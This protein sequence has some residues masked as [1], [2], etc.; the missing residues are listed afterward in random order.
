MGPHWH[1]IVWKKHWGI[2]QNVFFYVA[3]KKE[4]HTSFPYN[5]SYYI[6]IRQNLQKQTFL[7]VQCVQTFSRSTESVWKLIRATE[8]QQLIMAQPQYSQNH[9]IWAQLWLCKCLT[10]CLENRWIWFEFCHDW[11]FPDQLNDGSVSFTLHLHHAF[12]RQFYPR[13]L[14]YITFSVFILL[15]KYVHFIG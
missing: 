1:F 15:K 9:W 3:Q 2:S 13:P 4:R 7:L 12:G 5:V 10:G 14:V 8:T 6:V 11:G